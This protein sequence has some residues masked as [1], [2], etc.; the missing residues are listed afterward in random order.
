MEDPVGW[1]LSRAVATLPV[2]LDAIEVAVKPAGKTGV[3]MPVELGAKACLERTQRPS[4]SSG[5]P[6]GPAGGS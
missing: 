3:F 6:P 5:S 4:I 2:V 1:R